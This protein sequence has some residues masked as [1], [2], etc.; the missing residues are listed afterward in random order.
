MLATLAVLGFVHVGTVAED[1]E[2]II[3][4]RHRPAGCGRGGC[5]GVARVDVVV[6]DDDVPGVVDHVERVK[7]KNG[8]KWSVG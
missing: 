4:D 3:A 6:E 2:V 7:R 1:E 8:K 5:R